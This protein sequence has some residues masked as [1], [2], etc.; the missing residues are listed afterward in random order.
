MYEVKL[1]MSCGEILRNGVTQCNYCG[2]SNL[3]TEINKYNFNFD[4][5]ETIKKISSN[6]DFILSMFKLKCSDPIEYQ[7]KLS[8]AA[9]I[10]KCPKCGSTNIT[11]GQR[12]WSIVTGLIGSG[13]A[14]NRCANCGYK[15][16][17]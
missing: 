7:F 12:G 3:S 1:C 8:Q 10:V 14:V 2:S 9:N 4:E 15:W 6:A 5:Y 16:K 11:T 17:P 13:G